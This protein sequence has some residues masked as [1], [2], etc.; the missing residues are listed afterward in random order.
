[1]RVAVDMNLLGRRF[2]P[3]RWSM[4]LTALGVTVFCL[5]GNWQLQRA[6]YKESIENRFEQ[7]LAEDYRL[8]GADEKFDD[9]EYRK[10]RL[11]GRFDNSRHFLLDNQLHQGR[12]GYHVLTPLHL[13]DRDDI[14]LVDRGW[15][16][17][18]PRRDPL[19]E[20]RP[21]E[22]PAEVVGI[23]KIPSEPALDLGGVRLGDSWPQ[24][25]THVDIDALRQQYSADLLPMILWLAPERPGHYLREWNPVW[26]PPEK[27]RAYAVQWFAFAAVAIIL[28]VVLNLRKT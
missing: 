9:I 8:L 14:I 27:S 7:R 15:A 23:A 5:L 4:I 12:A 19:P 18:G 17:W 20:I 13:N 3:A 28:F 16:P 10:L 26:L 25:I 11:K 1:M 6:A 22:N 2:Q 21:V 24:L